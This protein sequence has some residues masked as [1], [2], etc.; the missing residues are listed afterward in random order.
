MAVKGSDRPTPDAVT[1][2]DLES[3]A[4]L[5]G[6]ISISGWKIDEDLQKNIER[7]LGANA[8]TEDDKKKFGS[9]DHLQRLA[10]DAIRGQRG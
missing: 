2:A 4:R 7:V 3:R 6:T 9:P 1:A 8:P 5:L 10:D